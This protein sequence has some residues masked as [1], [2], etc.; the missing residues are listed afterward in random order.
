MTQAVTA[1]KIRN[2]RARCGVGSAL[3][4]LVPTLWTANPLR[5]S[6]L[7]LNQ[8]E[9]RVFRE[10]HER[11]GDERAGRK[12]FPRNEGRRASSGRR[13]IV[14]GHE[15]TKGTTQTDLP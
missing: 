9:D 2:T 15:M 14:S 13:S 6:E 3:L 7:E 10:R 4:S 5:G 11:G 12:G 1:R 8:D